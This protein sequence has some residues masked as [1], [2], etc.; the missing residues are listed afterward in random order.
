MVD[1]DCLCPMC[2]ANTHSLTQRNKTKLDFK[3][4]DHEKSNFFN[5]LTF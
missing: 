3:K 1:N 5:G 4:L 2:G